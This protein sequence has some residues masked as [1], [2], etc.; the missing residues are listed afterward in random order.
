MVLAATVL[1]LASLAGAAPAQAQAAPK[2][3][4]THAISDQDIELMRHDMRSKKKQIIAQNFKL[5]DAEATRF[6][7]VYDRYAAD[8]T[9]INDRKFDLLQT[10]ADQFNTLTD[11]QAA[12]LLKQWLEVETEICELREKYLPTVS[13]VLPG[14]KVATFFQME[15]RVAMMIDMQLSSKTPLAQAQPQK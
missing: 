9:K 6:W 13:D 8:L 3:E 5:T 12:K 7:P 10:Y 11:D 2:A 1:A 14:K 15:R 4:E